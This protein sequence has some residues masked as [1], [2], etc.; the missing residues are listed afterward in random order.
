MAELGHEPCFPFMPILVPHHSTTSQ[1]NDGIWALPEVGFA[2][3][4]LE[5]LP[6]C[7][8]PTHSSSQWVCSGSFLQQW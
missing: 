1:R 5:A 3:E 7:P 6:S 8:T 2:H 4:T